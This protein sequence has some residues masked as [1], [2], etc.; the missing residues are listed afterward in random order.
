MKL[1]EERKAEVLALCKK[2]VSNRSYSGEENAVA[3]VLKCFMRQKQFDDFCTDKYG[4][5]IGKIKGDRTGNK[6]LFDGHMDTVPAD[7]KETWK[8]DPFVP[9]VEDGKLYG[10]GTSDMKGAVAAFFCAAAYFMEDHGKDFAG[11]IYTA[12][13][14]HEECFEGV[15][16]RNISELVNPDYVVIGEASEL[17]IKTGQRGRAEIILETFGKAAHSANPEKGINAVKKM[18]K[19]LGEIDRIQPPIHEQLGKGIL[20]VTDII[21]SPYPGASVVPEYCRATLDRRLLTG[22]T[23]ESILAPIQKLIDSLEKEDSEFSA[24]ASFSVGSER[25]YTGAEIQGERFFPGWYYAPEEKYVQQILQKIREAGYDPE[26]TQYSFCTNGSHYAGE[27][28]I[29]TI[30]LGPSREDLAHMVDEYVELTQLY[31]AVELKDAPI[32]LLDEATAS[33]DVENETKIQQ[34]L[35][36]LVKD[37]TVL[38]IAHRMRTI[39]NAD[40]IV[41]LKEGKVVEKGTLEELMSTNENTGVLIADY[42][43]DKDYE[44]VPAVLCKNHGPF[45]W[46]N[47]AHEAVHYAVVLEE[48][49]KMASRC[50]LILTSPIRILLIS[51]FSTASS[52]SSMV[53]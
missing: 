17:N 20:E 45:T 41:V 28:G 31:G 11:E 18:C 19:L 36:H 1:T 27:K 9:V 8:H 48:V 40:H 3:D 23:R 16:A 44:A 42:F 37:K 7:N 53:A 4:N 32:I 29:P 2:L 38:I 12:G 14:V 10:R 35:S 39:A 24:K 21:S 50:E 52:S 49:A 22:E 15:A 6:V 26:L 51:R 33:L 25:C 30:G 13:V 34:A 5:V 47:D 46:G 43:K